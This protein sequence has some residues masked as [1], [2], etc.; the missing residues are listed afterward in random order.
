MTSRSAGSTSSSSPATSVESR[1]TSCARGSRPDAT[2]AKA[3][4]AP[5]GTPPALLMKLCPWA[6]SSAKKRSSAQRLAHRGEGEAG[7]G[8]DLVG[9]GRRDL[10]RVEPAV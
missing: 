2:T 1:K 5:G 4:V 6:R 8:G 7:H 10:E 3:A 9:E